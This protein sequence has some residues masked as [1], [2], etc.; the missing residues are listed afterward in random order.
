MA[1]TGTVKDLLDGHVRLDIDCLD[2]LYMKGNV[3]NLQVGGQGVSFMPG[4][5][6]Y[7]IPSP[8]IMDKIGAVFR[9]AVDRFAVD[10]AIPVLRFST[11]DRKIDVMRPYL[12]AQAR[13]GRSGVAAIGTAQEFQNVFAAAQHMGDNGVPWFSFVKADR[14]GAG[15]FF[16]CLGGA[17]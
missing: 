6:G 3:P 1:G 9:K 15:F 10:N 4:H 7:P 8:A 2:R 13:T 14:R 17:F 12:A 11:D 5:V 16:F